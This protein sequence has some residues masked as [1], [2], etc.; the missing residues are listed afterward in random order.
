MHTSVINISLQSLRSGRDQT[1][2]LFFKKR[3]CVLNV[4]IYLGSRVLNAALET[5]AVAVVLSAI[6]T[7]DWVT[8]V[9][10]IRDQ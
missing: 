6:V 3:L 10:F 2:R 9:A 8:F 1:V 4:D 7:L 5:I